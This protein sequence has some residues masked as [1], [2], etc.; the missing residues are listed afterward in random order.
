ME[1]VN[2]KI[3]QAT[4]SE[5][6]SYYLTRE[7]DDVLSFQDYLRQMKECGTVIIKE[8]RNEMAKEP[9]TE[10]CREYIEEIYVGAK[11]VF[12]NGIYVRT[13]G[14]HPCGW[15][16]ISFEYLEC[17][18][19]MFD[20]EIEIDSISNSCYDYHDYVGKTMEDI[21]KEVGMNGWC[22]ELSGVDRF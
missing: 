22:Y 3:T 2:G 14:I 4:Q 6:Y 18:E 21:I 12:G 19:D 1:I 8:E 15:D 16:F 13:E 11:E 17:A 10:I 5:L 9:Y 20:Y 7:I